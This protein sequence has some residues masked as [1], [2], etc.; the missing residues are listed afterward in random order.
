MVFQSLCQAN[1]ETRWEC[2]LNAQASRWSGERSGCLLPHRVS[3]PSW[4]IT[5]TGGAGYFRTEIKWSRQRD[6]NPHY[7]VRSLGPYPLN[8]GVMKKVPVPV[9]Y[10]LAAD[11]R[12]PHTTPVGCGQHGG[13]FLQALVPLGW[14]PAPY[15]FA[16]IFG[17]LCDHQTLLSPISRPSADALILWH[18]ESI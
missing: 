4:V 3:L 8:D 2:Q 5:P 13:R 18:P 1:P 17:L 7:K 15:S 10:W 11:G 9:G 12:G 16:V 6:S 14:F